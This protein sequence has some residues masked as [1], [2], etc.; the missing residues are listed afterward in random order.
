MRISIVFLEGHPELEADLS[1]VSKN[2]RAERMR[3][4]ASIGLF[5]LRN[6]Q[7]SAPPETTQRVVKDNTPVTTDRKP[8]VVHAKAIKNVFGQV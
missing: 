6:G 3:M 7:S 8:G 5:T 1:K 4:L 2:G